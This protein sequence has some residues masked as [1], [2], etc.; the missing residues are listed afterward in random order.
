M[1]VQPLETQLPE[2]STEVAAVQL[3]AAAPTGPYPTSL[4]IQEATCPM[5]IGDNSLISIESATDI[6]A[7][8]DQ[9][10]GTPETTPAVTDDAEEAEGDQG[11]TSMGEAP[12]VE[13]KEETLKFNFAKQYL[14]W[15]NLP[16]LNNALA[17]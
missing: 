4:P 6:E 16:F 15:S 13:K 14:F 9:M 17:G 5:P 2:P 3:A 11:N 7:M 1:E 8:V 12:E 10:R